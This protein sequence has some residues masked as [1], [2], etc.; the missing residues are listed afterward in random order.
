MDGILLSQTG[1]V[2]R[3]QL[4]LVPTPSGTA[5]HKVIRHHEV[6]DALVDTLSLR[7]IAPVREEYAVSKDGMKMFGIIE[8]ETTFHGCRFAL[9][10]RNAH[11]KSMRLAM[12]CGY[13][14]AGFAPHKSL[15]RI[16]PNQ[17]RL[18]RWREHDVAEFEFPHPNDLRR[19]GER[20]SD[21]Q[22]HLQLGCDP[23][24]HRHFEHYRHGGEL[25]RRRAKGAGAG[26]ALLPQSDLVWDHDLAAI[27]DAGRNLHDN[28][29]L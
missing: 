9:G 29:F 19:P 2:D 10:V 21:L 16:K 23:A 26:I 17:Y 1:K 24:P 5:T 7:H 22:F 3:A 27:P 28:V 8:L 15:L 20:Q 25:Q 12:T 18:Q 6:I 13:R 14:F 4:A 11:D